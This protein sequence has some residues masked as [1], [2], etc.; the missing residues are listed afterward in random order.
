MDPNSDG[1]DSVREDDFAIKLVREMIMN[2][3]NGVHLEHREHF[4]EHFQR[5]TKTKR[6]INA[7]KP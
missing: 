7:Q 3:E 5:K 2:S 4:S 1:E 6:G